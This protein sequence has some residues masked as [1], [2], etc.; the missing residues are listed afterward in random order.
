MLKIMLKKLRNSAREK[1]LNLPT[2][3]SKYRKNSDISGNYICDC[4][5]DYTYK[6][7]SPSILKLKYII[8][9]FKR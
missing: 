4:F 2:L 5:N 7:D 3:Q 1:L 8:P 9:V 6:E